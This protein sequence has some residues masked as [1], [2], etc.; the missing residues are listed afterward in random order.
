MS[1]FRLKNKNRG[2]SDKVA[3]ELYISWPNLP[4]LNVRIILLAKL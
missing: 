2:E 4:T 3:R 1:V